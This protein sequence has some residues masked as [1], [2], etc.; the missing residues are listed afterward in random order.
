M[1][2]VDEALR[3]Y[4]FC[5][6]D[7][8]GVMGGSYGGYMTSWIV[9]HTDRFKAACSE[10]AVN[11]WHS[12][13]GASDFGWPFKAQF[14]TSVYE[15]PEG[16]AEMSPI[17]Y[18]AN[19]R[20]PLLILHSENDLRCPIE[21]AEQLFTILRLQKRDVEFVRFPAESHELSRGGSPAHRVMRFEIILDWF[22][23]KLRTSGRKLKA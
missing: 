1:A 14:G 18:A 21:Q 13:H 4:A 3:R 9:S 19:I 10:R 15:D 7:R 16:W 17:T 12:M 6:P 23:R 8:L 5:D 2:V 11:S 20:T 22:D